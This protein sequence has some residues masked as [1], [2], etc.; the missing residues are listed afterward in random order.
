MVLA[1]SFL[2]WPYK[3]LIDSLFFPGTLLSVWH[4]VEQCGGYSGELSCY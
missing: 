1:F 2:V 4:Q 3:A